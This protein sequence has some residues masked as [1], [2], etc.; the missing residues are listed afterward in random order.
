MMTSKFQME[1]LALLTQ[2][3]LKRLVLLSLL[4]STTPCFAATYYFSTSGN[5]TTGNGSQAA[6]F[7]SLCGPWGGS[8]CK[9]G[10]S[11]ISLGQIQAV[12][13]DQLLFKRGDE[14]VGLDAQWNINA[15][16]AA[17]NPITFGAWG[18]A[19]LPRPIFRGARS[20]FEL[21][22]DSWTNVV[23]TPIWYTNGVNSWPNMAAMED[24]AVGGPQLYGAWSVQGVTNTNGWNLNKSMVRGTYFYDSTLK[25]LY[26]WRTDN[27]KP[28]HALGRDI[29][30]G[31]GPRD[32]SDRLIKINRGYAGG[33]TDPKFKGSHYII[34]DLHVRMSAGYG[35]TVNY[36]NTQIINCLSELN[37]M[38]GI[39]FSR[40]RFGEPLPGGKD[41][42]IKDCVVR[43][44]NLKQGNGTGQGITIETENTW[45]RDS[46]SY[47]N[48]W[49][50]I[51]FLDYSTNTKSEGGGVVNCKVYHN[52]IQPVSSLNYDPNIYVDG[53]SNITIQD[54][55]VWGAGVDPRGIKTKNLPNPGISI[56]VEDAGFYAGKRPKGIKIINVTSYGNMGPALNIG[57]INGYQS[58][59]Q[60]LS[61]VQVIGS[62]FQRDRGDADIRGYYDASLV[63]E[64][65]RVV[66]FK[67][68]SSG[69]V[70]KNNIVVGMNTAKAMIFG[71]KTMIDAGDSVA[72][73]DNNIYYCPGCNYNVNGTASAGGFFS[74]NYIQ[75]LTVDQWR[76]L[77]DVAS[78]RR[79][80]TL[81]KAVMTGNPLLT[82]SLLS[83]FNAR[84]LAGS[85]A[86]DAA[87]V[88]AF[89][90]TLSGTTRADDALD[91]PYNDIGFHYQP[92]TT[93]VPPPP[94]SDT[95]APSIPAG[96]AATLN[97]NQVTLNWGASTDN[98]GVTG[99]QVFDASTL[100]T[101]VTSPV[102]SFTG[103]PGQNFNCT[104]KAFD[105][106]NNFSGASNAAVFTIPPVEP[107]ADTTAP[108]Q[109]TGLNASL[110]GTLISLVWNAATDNIGVTGYQ[111]FNTGSLLGA[112]TATAY[113]L[114]GTVG[115]TY[116]FTVKALDAA[117]NISVVS[118]AATLT[119]GTPPPPPTDTVSPT[120]PTNLVF[121][122]TGFTVNL[123]WTASTDDVGVTQYKIFEQGAL[124]GTSTTTSFSK[125]ISDGSTRGF[126]VLAEDASGKQSALSA[127]VLATAPIAGGP[128]IPG[129]L[130][131]VL[132]GTQVQLTWQPSSNHFGYNIWRNGNYLKTLP[133]TSTSSFDNAVVAGT[134]Y[135]YTVQSYN[136]SD[137]RSPMSNAVTLTI[138]GGAPADT[139]APTVPTSLSLTLSPTNNIVVNWAAS[140]DNV[141][142][143]LY[144]VTRN[145]V[146]LGSTS[147]LTY[148]ISN[149]LVAQTHT[150][151]VKACDAALNCSAQSTS[152]STT[153]PDITN[154]SA[155]QG[156]AA[157]INGS[158][159]A[160][161][162]WQ[163]ATDNVAVTGYQIFNDLIEVG[164]SVVPSFTFE[165]VTPGQ[166]YRFTVKASDA[167]NNISDASNEAVVP[168]V[169]TVPPSAPTQLSAA[170]SGTQALLTWTAAT[171]NINVT[172]YQV[173]RNGSL[174]GTSLTT[175][176]T[177][178]GLLSGQTET[179]SVK[180]LDVAGNVSL[181]S[182][183]VTVGA[184]APAGP[185]APK[186][187]IAYRYGSYITVAWSSVANA[188]GYALY[189]NDLFLKN[190]TGLTT[191]DKSVSGNTTYVYKVQAYNA[192]NNYSAFSNTMSVTMPSGP[193]IPGNL[194]G[195]R[196]NSTKVTLNWTASTNGVFGY[197]VY[198]NGSYYRTIPLST[199]FT[200][201]VVAGTNYTYK[202]QAYDA[203]NIK[204]PFSNEVAV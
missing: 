180:A 30:I 46:E 107:P 132:N 39:L 81:S 120:T 68:M 7:Y 105:A 18:D 3:F 38:E 140:T 53:G 31:Y 65:I 87:D 41:G 94:P 179:F 34:R 23:G 14:W 173:F 126:N 44:N 152:A 177:A 56:D 131:G 40:G 147:A 13:G 88:A 6:P 125:T 135:T 121:N 183:V 1:K 108:T 156:L 129:N 117:N 190:V 153:V 60:S 92:T 118:N 93:G 103:V 172:Q 160:L 28:D 184:A 116:D 189:R 119:V 75:N 115:Q 171:D 49:A 4:L 64:G 71:S 137:K 150:V 145:G 55:Q 193:S 166:I 157:V 134:T 62:T 11:K 197:N 130:V 114:T 89:P 22:I 101:T 45:V 164:S 151:S 123:S 178:T 159:Q 21:G 122:M 112:A 9:T 78:K 98:V 187:L 141:G 163:A 33:S 58:A 70:F 106:A 50:G 72:N 96:L 15:T 110:N 203:S 91:V 158:Q 67:N 148:T 20:A 168:Q 5:N 144:W 47:E 127:T 167:A 17:N 83:G 100:V 124:A 29:F 43:R 133:A 59:I 175:A 139:T 12:A 196:T 36:A 48:A 86:I 192:S 176:F 170:V 165:P 142:V 149:P 66:S 191:D 26:V 10:E 84:L 188:T 111:I 19:N 113:S 74:Y 181:S 80:E 155:P 42:L 97:G 95:T 37:A 146:Q 128:T 143:S 204:S 69:F 201:T 76:N 2:P 104:V 182:N 199:T 194:V 63:D 195:S 174:T 16:G 202:L 73:F 138:P 186:D 51:D 161:L 136:A 24:S 27:L 200:D 52:G 162:S 35:I 77:G 54:T 85:P 8:G 102:H 109:P 82:S 61:D 25:R 90:A 169:D 99:Y 79:D 32:G 198:R 57:G 185:A 154:P